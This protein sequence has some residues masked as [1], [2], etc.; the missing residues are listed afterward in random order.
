MGPAMAH[1]PP[2]S[3]TLSL[4]YAASDGRKNVNPVPGC[5]TTARAAASALLYS[6]S[7]SVTLYRGA[8]RSCAV[9]LQDCTSEL[10]ARKDTELNAKI[11]SRCLA[12]PSAAPSQCHELLSC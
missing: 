1:A 9:A 4:L 3:A 7:A 11:Y 5:G 6:R 2:L 8:N 10:Y 12:H